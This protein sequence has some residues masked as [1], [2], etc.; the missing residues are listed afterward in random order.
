ML[1]TGYT[2]IEIVVV[3]II[4]SLL[5]A[6]TAPRLAVLYDSVQAS[7]EKNEIM[8]Q[9][10]GL[11]Y[12]AFQQGQT[13]KLTQYPPVLAKNTQDTQ[14]NK[15]PTLEIPSLIKKEKTQSEKLEHLPEIPLELPNTWQL[16]TETPILFHAN[17]VCNGGIVQIIHQ[18]VTFEVQLIAPF[19]HPD[20]LK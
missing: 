10:N 5:A 6:M 18:E 2:L 1:Q 8:A 15:L 12:L 3:L 4:F 17:G 13:F 9:L 14:D 20:T 19:C 16:K 11:S 7:Y